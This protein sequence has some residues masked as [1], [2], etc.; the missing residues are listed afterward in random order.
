MCD[1]KKAEFWNSWN[2]I[3]VETTPHHYKLFDFHIPNRSSSLFFLFTEKKEN[4]KKEKE[5][6]IE[7][8]KILDLKKKFTEEEIF[9]S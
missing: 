3:M 5:E 4:S 6:K 9:S 8:N 7:W 1:L 2:I